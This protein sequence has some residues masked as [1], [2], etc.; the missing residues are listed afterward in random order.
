[1]CIRD[2]KGAFKDQD[3]INNHILMIENEIKNTEKI[4]R[5][6]ELENWINYLYEN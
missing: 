3:E 1:M 4:S 2:S 6:K 5:M